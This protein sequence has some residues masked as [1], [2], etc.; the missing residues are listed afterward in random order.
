MVDLLT[1]M[2]AVVDNLVSK[3]LFSRVFTNNKPKAKL[4]LEKSF[5]QYL[6]STKSY[7]KILIDMTRS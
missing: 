2:K 3:M 4:M 7:R 5:L 6:I 1:D